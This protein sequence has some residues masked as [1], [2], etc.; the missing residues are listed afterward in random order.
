[1]AKQTKSNYTVR[2]LKTK[3][4]F[5]MSKILKK[6]NLKFDVKS[7]IS[8]EQLG[9]EMITQLLGNLSNAEE[10]VNEFIGELVGV[11]GEEFSELE[12]EDTLDIINQFKNM[13]GISGFLK[14]AN[15]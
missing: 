13:E 11:T 7:G 1:M 8:Q 10:E 9:A 3:D 12:I 15:K 14:L 6:L 5:K 2:K 4:I